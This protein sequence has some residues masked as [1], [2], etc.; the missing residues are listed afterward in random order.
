MIFFYISL[1]FWYDEFD[2]CS[3]RSLRNSIC[4]KTIWPVC[5]NGSVKWSRKSPR[6][7]DQRNTSMNCAIKSM[8]WR[9]V[10]TNSWYSA[11]RRLHFSDTF[12]FM[13]LTANQRRNR[14]PIA[15][16]FVVLG[17]SASI[18]VDRRRCAQR[19]GSVQFGE[20]GSWVAFSRRP[21]TRSCIEIVEEIGWRPRWAK[22]IEVKMRMRNFLHF[23]DFSLLCVVAFSSK[24]K[25]NICRSLHVSHPH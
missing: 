24:P 10:V 22:Q 12:T 25:R 21:G 7:V 16:S 18:G 14:W 17:T 15:S 2:V 5:W 1:L 8:C 6:S 19:T 9:F 23:H 3:K 13:S 20:F 11:A 4:A